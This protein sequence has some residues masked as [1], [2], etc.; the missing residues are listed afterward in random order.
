[1]TALTPTRRQEIEERHERVERYAS[2][3]S[4]IA[5]GDGLPAHKDRGDLLA[6]DEAKDAEIEALRGEIAR[7]KEL[8]K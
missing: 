2:N 7:L 6:S 1:M 4:A 8:L 3:L 5:P